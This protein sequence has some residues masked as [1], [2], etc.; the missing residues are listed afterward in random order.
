MAFALDDLSGMF[1]TDDFAVQATIVLPA[2]LAG[3]ELTGI[4]DAEYEVV[5]IGSGIQSSAPMLTVPTSS[6]PSAMSTAF[7]RNE[8]VAIEIDGCTFTVVEPKPDGTGVT[9]LR[10]RK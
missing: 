3:R 8:E 6:I 1:D 10:L 9:T 7:D 2:D 4:F 5:D